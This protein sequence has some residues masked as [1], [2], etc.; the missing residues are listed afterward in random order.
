MYMLGSTQVSVG[1]VLWECDFKTRSENNEHGT[2]FCKRSMSLLP[3]V[4]NAIHLKG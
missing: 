3:P 4:P 1:E 2:G